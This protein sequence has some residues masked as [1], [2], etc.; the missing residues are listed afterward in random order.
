MLREDLESVKMVM[1]ENEHWDECAR[2]QFSPISRAEI[3]A[4]K[5]DEIGPAGEEIEWDVEQLEHCI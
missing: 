1:D 4:V 2:H 5:L 3:S